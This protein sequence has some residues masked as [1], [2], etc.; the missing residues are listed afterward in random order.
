MAGPVRAEGMMAVSP[1]QSVGVRVQTACCVVVVLS[2]TWPDPW[3]V[4]GG[5]PRPLPAP[6]QAFQRLVARRLARAQARGGHVG[7][8]PSGPT[9]TGDQSDSSLLSRR[10][11]PSAPS[12]Q[13]HVCVGLKTCT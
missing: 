9:C 4:E 12:L 6:L 13:Y 8:L 5:R 10:S 11:A 2:L 3:G 7:E 1:P